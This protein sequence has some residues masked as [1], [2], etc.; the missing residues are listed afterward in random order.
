MRLNNNNFPSFKQSSLG[1]S[2][3]LKLDHKSDERY[4]RH[5]ELVE[6]CG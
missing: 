2:I 6:L 4:P 1:V 3:F 5:P